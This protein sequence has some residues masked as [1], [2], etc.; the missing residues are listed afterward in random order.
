[1]SNKNDRWSALSLKDRADLMNMYITNGIS[2]LKEMKEHYN[3]FSGE[4]DTKTT[5]KPLFD[6]QKIVD[7]I[8]AREWVTVEGDTVIPGVIGPT[9]ALLNYFINNKRGKKAEE[10]IN[11]IIEQSDNNNSQYEDALHYRNHA[12]ALKKYLGL[13]Y[14]KTVIE[15]SQYK[16]TKA[17]NNTSK[18]YKF[19]THNS[20]H[21]SSIVEDMLFHNRNEKHYI[22]PTLHE[23][24]ANRG[25]D[26]KGDYISIYD[27]WNYNPAVMG[28][29]KVFD[30]II[31]K[32]TGGKPFEIYDRVYLDDYYDIPEN[33]RGNPFIA[34]AVL[35]DT[36]AYMGT[37]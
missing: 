3:N 28:G 36:N 5:T 15:E 9:T 14:D 2:G 26:N 7:N 17:K 25:I 32:V 23:V 11:S 34:P 18:Y 1:M 8:P 21:L 10:K 24:T 31:D 13:P 12:E 6:P 20:E 30:T 22:D 29:S 33:F 16:P 27:V 4:E 19:N 35:T 37:D